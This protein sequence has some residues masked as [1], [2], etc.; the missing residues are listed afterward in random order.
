MTTLERT[1]LAAL[2]ATPIRL[3]EGVWVEFGSQSC[4]LSSMQDAVLVDLAMRVSRDFPIVFIDTG[5]H[6]DETWQTLRAIEA[7]YRIDVEVIAPLQA[8]KSR[9]EV[10]QCCADKST[11][12]DLALSGRR[13]WVSGLQRH[14]TDTRAKA[15][16]VELDR[17][18]LTKVNPLAQWSTEDRSRF[19]DESDLIVNP[20]LD[21]GYTSIGCAPCT[22]PPMISTDSRSGRWAG[23]DKTECGLH[24]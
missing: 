19:I 6:F 18:G 21:Q 13:A 7:R 1:Q 3:L 10:A 15:P 9:V 20:L 5:Y 22:T 23:T 8:P 17:R 24:L 16:L 14:Q 4:V 2:I 11:Q 12:L